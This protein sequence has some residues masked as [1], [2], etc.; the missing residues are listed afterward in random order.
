MRSHSDGRYS[1]TVT[2]ASTDPVLVEVTI[3]GQA[4][5]TLE[6]PHKFYDG[7]ALLELLEHHNAQAAETQGIDSRRAA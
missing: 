5:F 7:L 1:V 3:A 6:I 4:S 2:D